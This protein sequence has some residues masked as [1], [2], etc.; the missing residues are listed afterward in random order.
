[1]S[2]KAPI[3][4]DPSKTA[5]A[6]APEAPKS[7]EPA[8][9]SKPEPVAEAPAAVPEAPAPEPEAKPEEKAPGR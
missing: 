1:M 4:K 7:T 8:V 2:A 3:K 6:K 9:E 5:A